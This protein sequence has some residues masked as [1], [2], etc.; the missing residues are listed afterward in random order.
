MFI[1]LIRSFLSIFII[2]AFFFGLFLDFLYFFGSDSDRIIGD[3]Q[4]QMWIIG[5]LIIIVSWTSFWFFKKALYLPQVIDSVNKIWWLFV[6]ESIS[7]S[8]IYSIISYIFQFLG[9]NYISDIWL[10]GYGFILIFSLVRSLW[11]YI[12]QRKNN[13]N[14]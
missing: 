1:W 4:W 10:I 11:F 13:S 8:I 5:L 9:Y 2:I 14:Y 3:S 6:F 7:L 12:S